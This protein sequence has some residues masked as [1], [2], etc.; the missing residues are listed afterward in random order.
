MKGGRRL[1]G[2]TAL[3][4]LLSVPAVLADAPSRSLLP[5]QRG[6]AEPVSEVARAVTDAPRASLRPVTR[7]A[8]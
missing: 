7:G 4:C 6:A 1:A 8:P 3:V 2:L 5:M